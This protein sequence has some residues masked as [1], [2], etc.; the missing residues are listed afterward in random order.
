MYPFDPGLGHF[1]L[2]S[3]AHLPYSLSPPRPDRDQKVHHCSCDFVGCR[4]GQEKSQ[5]YLALVFNLRPV[6]T[7]TLL[8]VYGCIRIIDN[9]MLMA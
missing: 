6:V 8:Y 3:Q 9:N 4:D 5:Y 1:H 2:T 7:S